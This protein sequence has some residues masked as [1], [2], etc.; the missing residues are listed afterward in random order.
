[1]FANNFISSKRRLP[2]KEF[3]ESVCEPEAPE[4]A[5]VRMMN[6]L[7]VRDVGA[8]DEPRLMAVNGALHMTTVL[9]RSTART[10]T[11]TSDKS[12]RTAAIVG[13]FSRRRYSA[14]C[15][16]SCV[17]SGALNIFVWLLVGTLGRLVGSLTSS[18][19]LP[20]VCRADSFITSQQKK[21][22]RLFEPF[23]RTW[24][25]RRPRTKETLCRRT[26]IWIFQLD[27]G[28]RRG[29]PGAFTSIACIKW[30]NVSWIES[31]C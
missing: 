26:K 20:F 9:M 4:S 29:F 11:S 21:S 14:V 7:T 18:W 28:P 16:A 15:L 25:K 22:Q 19:Q 23:F 31:R 8:R 2:S 6:N 12:W 13:L 1:M 27:G 24:N 17:G 10:L 30:R 3:K 5:S